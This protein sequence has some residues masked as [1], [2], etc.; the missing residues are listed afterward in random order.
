MSTIQYELTISV[1]AFFQP[2]ST[3]RTNLFRPSRVPAVQKNLKDMQADEY[4][5]PNCTITIYTSEKT[6]VIGF[7]SEWINAYTFVSRK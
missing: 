4:P 5:D 7:I 1:A 2:Y 6:T 3:P